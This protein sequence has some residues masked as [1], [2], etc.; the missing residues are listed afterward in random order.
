MN[1][2]LIRARQIKSL[3]QRELTALSR[4]RRVDSVSRSLAAER[5]WRQTNDQIDQI[6]A[7]LAREM[8]GLDDEERALLD[9]PRRPAYL[10]SVE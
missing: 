2:A 4:N 3:Y 7:R 9:P 8:E 10:D 5:L 1:P 6:R